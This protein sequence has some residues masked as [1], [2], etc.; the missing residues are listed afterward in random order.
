MSTPPTL[1]QELENFLESYVYSIKP[2]VFNDNKTSA[3]YTLN[4]TPPDL[5]ILL[6][7]LNSILSGD[8]DG[9]LVPDCLIPDPDAEPSTTPASFVLTNLS[10]G[11]VVNDTITGYI[12]VPIVSNCYKNSCDVNMHFT[13]TITDEIQFLIN[14]GLGIALSLL[15]EG[16]LPGTGFDPAPGTGFD[17][18]PGTGTEPAPG[19]GTEPAPAPGTASEKI[20]FH[21][22]SISITGCNP[23]DNYLDNTTPLSA[24]CPPPANGSDNGDDDDATTSTTTTPT[25]CYSYLDLAANSKKIKDFLL[26]FSVTLVF[27]GKGLPHLYTPGATTGGLAYGGERQPSFTSF[28]LPS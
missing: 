26:E 4:G 5:C 21:F 7:A 17:P 13:L 19:T 23:V 3:T 28:L 20:T 12:N 1:V 11:Q 9:S 16:N 2:P 8:C 18:A 25:T 15:N 27:S 22:T 24:L 6:P 14:L 10:D